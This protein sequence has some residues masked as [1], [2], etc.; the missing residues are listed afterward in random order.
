[1]KTALI[2]GISGQD[3][4]YFAKL[5]LDKGYRVCGMSREAQVCPFRNLEKI[6]MRHPV[7]LESI[8]LNDFRSVIQLLVPICPFQRESASI[9]I[10]GWATVWVKKQSIFKQCPD[11]FLKCSQPQK[12]QEL[13]DSLTARD[14]LSFGQ[15]WLAY[16]VPFFKQSER[17]QAGCQHRLFFSHVEY[18]DNPLFHRRAALDQLG[19][20]LLDA[21]WSQ[22]LPTNYET[23]TNFSFNAA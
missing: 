21:S 17:E 7:Q 2:T 13:A 10:T 23:R 3:G 8:A 9:S 4:A 15:K 18:R 11:A 6:Q 5:L 16:L 12:L 20:R 1:M 14:L 19:Q 22:S